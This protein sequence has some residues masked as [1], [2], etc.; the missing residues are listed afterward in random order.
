M[1]RDNKLTFTIKNKINHSK[2]IKST[3]KGME[4]VTQILDL[5]YANKYEL[6]NKVEGEFFCVEL[7]MGLKGQLQ[8]LEKAYS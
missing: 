5:Y 6:K 2:R 1:V 7:W 4:N 8:K 3:N